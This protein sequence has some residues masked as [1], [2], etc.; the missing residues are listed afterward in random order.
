MFEGCNMTENE[1]VETALGCLAFIA[2]GFLLGCGFL[3]AVAVL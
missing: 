1:F 3:L 2:A